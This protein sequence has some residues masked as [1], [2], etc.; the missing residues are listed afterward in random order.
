[1]EPRERV[2]DEPSGRPGSP[3]RIPSAADGGGVFTLEVCR[4]MADLEARYFWFRARNRLITWAIE[5]FC[6]RA[7]SFLDVGCGTG[8]VLSAIAKA[9]PEM[10]LYGSEVF[11]A[12]LSFAASR[13]PSISFTQ[14]DSLHIP[15]AS[16]FDAIGLFDV[17]EHVPDDERVLAQI[18]GGLK[19]G[20]TV[21]LTVPQH[22]WLWSR[23]DEEAGHFRRYSLRDLHGKLE[24]A[25]FQVVR[26]TSFMTVVLPAMVVARAFGKNRPQEGRALGSEFRIS[27]WLN[28]LFEKA[29]AV[30]FSVIARHHTLPAGGSRLIVARRV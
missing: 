15:F 24:A 30:E 10:R 3:S 4:E 19:P 12:G 28:S 20:G 27:P 23:V 2:P 17:L 11:S 7:R 25:G 5:E 21:I 6:P 13:H 14:M 9:R 1:M 18:H 22:P 16:A 8:F 29:L 26:S